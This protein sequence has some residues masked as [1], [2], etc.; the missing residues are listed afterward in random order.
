MLEQMLRARKAAG[1]AAY[2]PGQHDG[3]CTSPYVVVADAGVTPLGK[4]TGV[5][6]FYV[7]ACVPIGAPL[8]MA[9]TMAAAKAA[10]RTVPGIRDTGEISGEDI[11]DEAQCRYTSAAYH[12]MVSLI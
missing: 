3:R 6:V 9:A 11:D 4:T 10:L 7:T 12:A 5:R 2:M 8:R 1:V